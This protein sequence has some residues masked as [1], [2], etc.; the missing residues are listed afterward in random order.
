[1]GLQVKASWKGAACG[2]L[3]IGAGFAACIGNF[4]EGKI[5]LIYAYRGKS[6]ELRTDLCT[7]TRAIEEAAEDLEALGKPKTSCG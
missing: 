3:T 6:G 5:Y 1:M 4:E 2:K 7:R